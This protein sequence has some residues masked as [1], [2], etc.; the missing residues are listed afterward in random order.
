[1]KQFALTIGTLLSLTLIWIAIVL[2]TAYYFDGVMDKLV[3]INPT[4]QFRTIYVLGVVLIVSYTY[5]LVSKKTSAY[6]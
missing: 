2:N 6:L 1:M 4:L 3:L 5:I